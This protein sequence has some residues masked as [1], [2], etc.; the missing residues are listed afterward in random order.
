M[1]VLCFKATRDSE[2]DSVTDCYHKA[3][4]LLHSLTVLPQH[5]HRTR[6]NTSQGSRPTKHL[7][8]LYTVAVITQTHVH[9]EYV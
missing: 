2:D 3:M 9:G 8:R 6:N 5:S 4:R 7:S 1:N